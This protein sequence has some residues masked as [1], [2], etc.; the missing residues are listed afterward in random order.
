MSLYGLYEV[1]VFSFVRAPHNIFI[2]KDR[3]Y[4]SFEKRYHNIFSLKRSYNET[5]Y[6]SSFFNSSANVII[7]IKQGVNKYTKVFFKHAFWVMKTLNVTFPKGQT[8][9]FTVDLPGIKS[10]S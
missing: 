2:L 7:K 3:F 5:R 1:N 10:K 4:E 6:A 9:K 8:K